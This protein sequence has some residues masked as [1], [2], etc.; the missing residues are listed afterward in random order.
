M[1]GSFDHVVDE[2]GKY[3]GVGLLENTGDMT[4]AVEEMA[5]MLLLIKQRWGGDR[6]ISDAKEAYYE[7]LRGELPWP[8]WFPKDSV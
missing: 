7:R 4:E 6:I 3:Q 1:A 8:D 5:F 2:D